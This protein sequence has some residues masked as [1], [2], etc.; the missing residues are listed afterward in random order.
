MQLN[1]RLVRGQCVLCEC[2]EDMNVDM[3]YEFP[4]SFGQ[5]VFVYEPGPLSSMKGGRT[6][7]DIEFRLRERIV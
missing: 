3:R 1:V 7:P 6:K 5:K 2:G 4:L